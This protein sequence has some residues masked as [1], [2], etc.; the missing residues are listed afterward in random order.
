MTEENGGGKSTNDQINDLREA[1]RVIEE[2]NRMKEGRPESPTEPDPPKAAPPEKA[3]ERTKPAAVLREIISSVTPKPSPQKMTREERLQDRELLAQYKGPAVWWRILTALTAIIPP[4]LAFVA[5]ID[6]FRIR[7]R[8]LPVR[9][10][11]ALHYCIL[12]LFTGIG[13]NY[14]FGKRTLPYLGS[15]ELWT[16]ALSVFALLFPPL[17]LCIVIVDMLRR[18]N[19]RMGPPYLLHYILLIT[20]LSWLFIKLIINPD[21]DTPDILAI[22][23]LLPAIY[24]DVFPP[25]LFL[26]IIIGLIAIRNRHLASRHSHTIHY[27]R[28]LIVAGAL[29]WILFAVGNKFNFW[30]T[31]EDFR[32]SQPASPLA[33]DIFPRHTPDA[34]L[35]AREIA[36]DY[37][38]LVA[39]LKKFYKYRFAPGEGGHSG[40]A[41]VIMADQ[42]NVF[43]LTCLHVAQKED[44]EAPINTK[45]V[46]SM[47]NKANGLAEI[48]GYHRSYDLAIIRMRRGKRNDSQKPEDFFMPIRDFSSIEIGEP[49]FVIGNPLGQDFSISD[50]IV[51][52]KRDGEYVQ[53]SA[54]ISPGNSGGPV[55][56]EHGRLMAI[57]SRSY[58]Y[59]YGAQN[60]NQA[61]RADAVF[62]TKSWT[63]TEEAKKAME[64]MEGFQKKNDS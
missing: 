49:L 2:Y 36:S 52:Q 23:N 61:V 53:L 30:A 16:M 44:N 62:D 15:E 9:Y 29:W 6:L 59:I 12:L 22:V 41:V 34:D 21:L 5:T 39:K 40:S 13:Y 19:M 1:C 56:D 51:S 26:M 3:H 27:S 60:L 7:N 46:L 10:K 20:G 37:I 45:I 17:L 57:T 33:I 14:F 11:Y 43:L 28:L 4:F 35:S 50:G 58:G 8:E 25:I 32:Y 38:P 54:P 42:D 63:L 55:F 31:E 24:T 18:R 64:K 48:A 47:E